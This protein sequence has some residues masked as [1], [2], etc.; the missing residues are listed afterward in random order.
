[1]DLFGVLASYG[2]ICLVLFVI[3]YFL[4]T[5]CDTIL[6]LAESF[7]K[8]VSDFK[9]K[10][11]WVTGAST[12]LGEAM[13]YELASVGAKLIL[14]ARSTDKLQK[15]REECIERSNGKLSKEDILILPFDISNLECHKANVQDAVNHFGKIDV[16]VNNAA[17]YQVGEIIETDMSV[18]R[19][20][21]DI[22]FFG[23]VSLTK[24]VIKQFL[25]QGA[26]HIVVISSIDG[27]FG[28]PS[29][30]SYAGTKHALQ[31]YFDALHMEYKQKNISVTFVVPGIFSSSI[32]EKTITTKTDKILQ[33]EY[34][35][36]ECANMTSERCAHLALVA[37]VNK[38]YES[39]IAY[40][41]FLLMLWS[42]Q[43]IPDIYK[44]IMSVIY[45]KKRLSELYAG[46]WP[47]DLP[48][49]R[50]LFRKTTNRLK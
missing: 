35:H 26:G 8:K 12:G 23:P 2:G 6:A 10:V 48:V 34:Y 30:A 16:L 29:T 20:V 33:K 14:T 36:Y 40:Q 38:L 17:R 19:A 9:G 24:L 7:G 13:S 44:F 37:S 47:S 41:P 18:D 43:Y 50:P 21:F 28:V 25:Q 5:D 11:V 45:N 1:M 3:W 31:G 27:K 32:F 15:V 49:W 42:A 39:W 22:N 46:K 4:L